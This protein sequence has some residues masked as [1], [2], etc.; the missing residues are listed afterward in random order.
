M[1]PSTFQDSVAARVRRFP[2]AASRQARAALSAYFA[3]EP[4]TPTVAAA[5]VNRSR[6][7]SRVTPANSRY[8][9]R[10]QRRQA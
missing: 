10:S 1:A 3:E 7:S 2:R 6:F 8:F 4:E 9:L 5:P